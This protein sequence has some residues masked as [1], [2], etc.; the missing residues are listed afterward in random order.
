MKL[1]LSMLNDY[2]DININ[3]INPKDFLEKLTM[4]GQKV[5][6]IEEVGKNI[7][8]IVIGEILKIEKHP[9][10]DKLVVCET[11]VGDEVIQV[12][13][14]AT[15]VFEGAFVP[16]AK[17]GAV[18]A[19]GTKIKKGKLRGVESNGMFCSIQELGFT[20]NEYPEA[21][22][23]G[24]Y[25]FGEKVELGRCAKEA[26]M[27]EEVVAE[28]E[29]TS[30][31]PDCF[32]II[33]L[34]REVGA[35]YNVPFKVKKPTYST[36]SGLKT[37]DYINVKIEDDNCNR[38]KCAIVKNVKVEPSPLWLR[39]RLVSAGLRPINN[40]VDITNYILME[41]GQPMHAFDVSVVGGGEIVVR[42]SVEGEKIVS[43]DGEE[44]NLPTG[45]MVIADKVTPIAIAGIIGGENTKIND[46]TTTVL[47][48]CANFDGT[49]IRL[50]SKKIGVRTDSS[51]KFEKGLDPNT[52]DEALDRALE[53]VQLLGCGEEISEE[54]VDVYTNK[55]TGNIVDFSY[56]NICKTIGI[57]LTN[58]EIDKYLK[59]FEIEVKEGKA[60]APSFRP[61]IELEADL[62]EEVA[63]LYGYDKIPATL[64]ISR[65][66]VGKLTREQ[67][68]VK[69]VERTLISQGVSEI[70]NF[71]FESPN[72][73]E[74]LLLGADYGKDK[75][76]IISNPLGEDFS[77]MRITLIN[78]MLN[79]LS[80]NYNNRNKR[81]LFFEIGK[82]YLAKELPL[83]ELPNERNTLSLG[84]YGKLDFY[85]LKGIVE[86]LFE[87]LGICNYEFSRENSIA[88]MHPTRTANIKIGDRNVGYIGA[89][90]H[91]VA[92]NYSIGTSAY[93]AELDLASLIELA[94]LKIIYKPI[95]KFPSSSRDLAFVIDELLEVKEIE[96]IIRKNGG[97]ILESVELFDV[98]RGEQVGKDK[99]SVAY[100]LVL[101]SSEGTL[102][103]EEI[104]SVMNKILKDLEAKLGIELRK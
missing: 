94:D 6:V 100:Q 66:T 42:K 63:R 68:I 22:E 101:R 51:T 67:S 34:A 16:V 102:K 24:I 56:E 27:I 92:E 96:K 103:E 76:I 84:G 3:E 17:N 104:T 30:N 93:V 48:E 87:R 81:V 49:N 88:Y 11:N 4:V 78:G 57:D 73:F 18:L 19:D 5:E 59:V 71:S 20:T 12:V 46:D 37:S 80:T 43:L 35:A 53:L 69:I 89:V 23:N 64:A 28:F 86:V 32:S 75:S 83:K 90:H 55:V 54:M 8:N 77:A 41:Y 85:D 40:F 52:I 29:I 31:R 1:P 36:V 33:G 74:K 50:S 99:K 45:T 47:F 91:K 62:T 65:P 13:T 79:A 72:I 9:D 38:Y 95:P 61:D 97:N 2:L 10:A 70:K 82:V 14:G 98:F 21:H 60:Y 25:I 44:R 7:T 39:R 58:E 26:L 15:N